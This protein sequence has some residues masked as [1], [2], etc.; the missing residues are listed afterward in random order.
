MIIHWC[1]QTQNNL[2]IFIKKYL[3]LILNTLTIVLK[4]KTFLIQPN[5][6]EYCYHRVFVLKV[7]K[8]NN[9]KHNR[10]LQYPIIALACL[11]KFWSDSIL[12]MSIIQCF[13][14]KYILIGMVFKCLSRSTIVLV[15]PLEHLITGRAPTL[16]DNCVTVTMNIREF[17]LVHD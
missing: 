11:S 12:C 6:C 14:Y 2:I 16:L 17:F 4:P 8:N 7:L 5:I 13:T 1:S 10:Y 3:P 9:I 15:T